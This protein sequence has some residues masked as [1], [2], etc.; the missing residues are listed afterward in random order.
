MNYELLLLF[1]KHTATLSEQ[2]KT[3]SQETLE[4][5][6]NK[7]M[8]IFSLS[9]AINLSDEGKWQ[10]AVTSFEETISVFNITIER[11]GFQ[12]QHQVIGFSTRCM[13]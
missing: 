8:E 10:L 4:L 11:T 5:P 6:L 12:F 2:T 7:Q 3:K 13:H 9:P 1:K